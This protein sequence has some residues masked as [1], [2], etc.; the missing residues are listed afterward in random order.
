V[1]RAGW[2]S[3]DGDR[4]VSVAD[5]QSAAVALV[6]HHAKR[7]FLTT[8]RQE[9][10]PFRGLQ[11][12]TFVVRSIEPPDLDGFASATALQMRGPFELEGERAILRQFAIDTLVTKNSGGA[13]AAPKL[14]AARQLGVRVIMVQRPPTPDV[15]L[16]EGVA[17]ALAW[18]E[19][20]LSRRGTS[21]E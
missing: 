15:P 21:A 17:E 2:R 5:L 9:L 16:V 7:V 4:W 6:T 14:E 8:G 18:I 20:W 1:Y 10:D 19:K 3:V 11:G 13:A 12:M